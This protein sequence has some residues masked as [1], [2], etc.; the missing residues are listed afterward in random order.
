MKLNKNFIKFLAIGSFNTLLCLLLFK[1]LL[2]FNINYLL[3]SAIMNLFGILE[4]YILNAKLL[5]KTN[6]VLHEL[7][8][9]FNVYAVA[10]T[11][12]LLLMYALVSW[13][14]LPKFSA[15]ILTTAILTIIN[16]QLVKLFV[17]RK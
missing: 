2:S 14:D 3:A 15:Q 11:V 16:Y 4:G 12:N 17:F 10:F 7:L 6:L 8:K 5:Y 9:Y 13:L 1:W